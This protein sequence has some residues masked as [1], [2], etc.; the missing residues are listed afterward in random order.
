MGVYVGKLFPTRPTKAWPYIKA[1][2]LLADDVTHLHAIAKHIGLKRGWFQ[3]K[4]V[5]HYDLTE[6]MRVRAIR[7]GCQRLTRRQ[8]GLKVK[9]L[10]LKI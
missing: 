4:S 2:H 5:P 3:N 9:E 10:R 6:S 8:E 7:A 1:A